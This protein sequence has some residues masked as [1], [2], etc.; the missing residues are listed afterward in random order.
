MI[1]FCPIENVK[2]NVTAPGSVPI[3][4]EFTGDKVIVIN[5]VIHD[6]A[7][8]LR[9]EIFFIDK[10]QK[11]VLNLTIFPLDYKLEI[12]TALSVRRQNQGDL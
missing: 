7:T 11:T 8:D 5:A 4:D 9:P 2:Y 1:Y 10:D 3:S 12:S 6:N